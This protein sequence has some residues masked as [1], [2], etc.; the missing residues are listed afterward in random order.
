MYT[1]KKD[2]CWK[3]S[4]IVSDMPMCSGGCES[5]YIYI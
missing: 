1:S 4:G 5:A 2:M 3:G